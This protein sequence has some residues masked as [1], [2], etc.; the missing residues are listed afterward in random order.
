MP[1]AICEINR[2][3]SDIIS[4]EEDLIVFV[5]LLRLMVILYYHNPFIEKPIIPFNEWL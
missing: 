1:V 2:G 4:S 5:I 3:Q